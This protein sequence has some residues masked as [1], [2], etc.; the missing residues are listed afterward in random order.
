MDN[1]NSK[2]SNF[3]KKAFAKNKK[4]KTIDQTK[5]QALIS[6]TKEELKIMYNQLKSFVQSKYTFIYFS[7]EIKVHT[8][9]SKFKYKFHPLACNHSRR[10]L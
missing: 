2:F 4:L 6:S 1:L 7:A 5:N 8:H 9:Y 10:H 3:E